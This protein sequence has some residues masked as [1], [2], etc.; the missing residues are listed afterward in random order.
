MVMSQAAHFSVL[1]DV[2]K[3]NLYHT[4]RYYV[5]SITAKYVT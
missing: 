2:Y 3:L 5:D 1:P 4:N